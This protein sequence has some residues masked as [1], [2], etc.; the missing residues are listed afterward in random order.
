MYLIEAEA[1][2]RSGKETEAKDVLY[3]MARDRN[4]QYVK[5]TNAGQALID[6]I[7]VQ[8]RIELWGEGRSWTDLKRLSLPMVRV[9]G[10]TAGQGLH[11]ESI[12]TVITVPAG[13]NLWTWM[14]P[15]SEIDANPLIVQ[16]PS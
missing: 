7:L 11:I 9:M 5:S 16:N 13:G 12:A 1:L 6:E 10:P 15:Q 4:P 3:I 14:I 2:A 8:R